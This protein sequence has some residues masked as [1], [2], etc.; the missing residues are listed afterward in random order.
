VRL[1]AE[2]IGLCRTEHMCFGENKIDAVREMILAD[3]VP[4]RERALKKLL[5]LQRADSEGIFKAM[6][7]RPV[8]IRTLDPPLH[9]FLPQ[10]RANIDHSCTG[11]GAPGRNRPRCRAGPTTLRKFHPSRSA[12]PVGNSSHLPGVRSF[13]DTRV[14]AGRTRALRASPSTIVR[15][16][17]RQ[18]ARSRSAISL[19]QDESP[20]RTAEPSLDRKPMLAKAGAPSSPSQ[21]CW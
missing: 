2:G 16:A 11:S 19:A 20:A 5:P 10:D 12:R 4:A 17:I 14:S 21:S 7:D 15:S 3:S 18:S 8:T 9:E 1:A 13:A 6:Q